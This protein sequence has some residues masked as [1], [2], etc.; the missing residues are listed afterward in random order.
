MKPLLRA[1]MVLAIAASTLTLQASCARSGDGGDGG[2]GQLLAPNLQNPTPLTACIATECPVPWGSCGGGL[3]TTNTSRDIDNCGGCGVNCPKQPPSRHASSVCTKGKCAI[4][5]DELSA[6]CNK[7]DS[8]GCEVYTGDDPKNCGGCGNVCKDGEICWKGACGCPSGFSTC[9]GEC[10]NLQADN[11]S[12]GACDSECVAPN[13]N[14]PAWQCGPG[15]QPSSTQWGCTG[16]GCSIVCE[17]FR[18]NC[19]ANLCANGCEVNLRTDKLNCG[20]CGNACGGNQDC[21]DGTCICPE[22]ATRCDKLCVDLAVDT[23]NCG[24]CGKGCLGAQDEAANGGPRCVAGKCSY[25]CY[26]GWSDCDRLLENGCEANISSDQQNCGAC[27]TKCDAAR[28]QPCV[29]GQCLTKPC[30]AVPA[31]TK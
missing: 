31:G 30:D 10:K 26:A 6:N 4:A 8:D 11:S 1:A 18:G 20:T 29:L 17:A 9:G 7:D 27:G 19:D 22:G 21:V 3:C 13:A 14:D 15:I 24:Q 5:C 16:G 25:V 2:D 28:G 12:C 23:N